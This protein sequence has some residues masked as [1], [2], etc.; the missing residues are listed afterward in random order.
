[1]WLLWIRKWG[2]ALIIPDYVMSIR[3]HINAL[4]A[5]PAEVLVAG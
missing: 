3:Q 1:M 5:P 2:S 4:K